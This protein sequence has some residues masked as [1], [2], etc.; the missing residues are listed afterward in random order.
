MNTTW[1]ATRPEPDEFAPFYAGYVAR[2]PDGDIV[3]TLA[4]QITDTAKLLRSLPESMGDHR[5][6]PDKWSI[7]EVIGHMADGERIFAYRA[8]RFARG[9]ET[10]LPGFDENIYVANADFGTRTIDDLMSEFE[11]LRQATVHMLRGLDEAA[12]S[13]RG[14]ANDR[15]ISVRALAFIMA[16]HERHH[17]EIP[18]TRYL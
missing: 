10:P 17:L 5:Y 4:S 2:V 6:G 3:E 7:R 9:D 12:M 13:R 8:L 15:E 1:R 16:G 11:H 14:S 18:R